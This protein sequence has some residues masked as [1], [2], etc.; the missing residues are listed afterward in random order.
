MKKIKFH[1]KSGLFALIIVL[2]LLPCFSKG[3]QLSQDPLYQLV[4][5]DNFDSIDYDKWRTDWYWGNNMWNT[6]YIISC[7]S[8]IFPGR[9]V[10]VAY[11]TQP[12]P[13]YDTNRTI[14]TS[15]GVTYETMIYDRENFNANMWVFYK[16]CPS[17][18][19]S[20]HTDHCDSIGS[21][22]RYCLWD[23]LMPFK[24]SGAMMLGKN[25]F[26]YGYIEMRYTVS[27]VGFHDYN[28]YGPNL[29][30]WASDDSAN[31]SEIDIF[32]QKG[33]NWHM[34]MNFHFRKNDPS[35]PPPQ[36]WEDTV[37][38]HGIGN[39]VTITSPYPD[40]LDQSL[41]YDGSSWHTVGCE[42]TPDHIDTYYDSDDTTRRFSVSKLPVNRMT[43][44]PLVIDNYM[45]AAQYCIPFIDTLTYVPF[46]YKIDYV[47]VYQ[48]KQVDNCISTSGIFP[49][50]ATN[51]YNS[52]LYGDLTIGG[53]GSAI[54]N[55]GSFHLAGQDFVLLQSGF[56]ASGTA[57]VIIST[58]PCQSGQLMEYIDSKSNYE[59]LDSSIM[60]DL[61]KAK[62]H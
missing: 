42:W 55:S 46:E 15:G 51:D 41:A 32:E 18:T 21:D 39:P 31:Y 16:P 43:A 34:G 27:N 37:F 28:A 56:E 38:W 47:R 62:H 29:W 12:P 5:Q 8:N 26:K 4:F 11:N 24:F 23:S 30:M 61:L 48:I 9:I 10:D 33:T 49:S 2:M 14:S 59:P 45:P 60:S 20:L 25:K 50:F 1:L 52:I 36:N 44:M 57:D 53:G 13:P 19:C 35:S 7:D 6:N 17:D 54:L 3:Q 58:T 22:T 40:L